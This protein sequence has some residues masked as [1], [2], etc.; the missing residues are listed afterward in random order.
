MGKY[1]QLKGQLTKF[2]GEPDYQSRV[3][4]EKDRIKEALTECGESHSVKNF[5]MFLIKAKVEKAALEAKIKEQNL[6]IEAMNQILVEMLEAET[7]SSFK[8]ENAVSISI[9]DDVYCSIS[10]K[11]A[12]YDWIKQSGLEDLFTVNYQT[13]SSMVKRKLIDGEEVPP[14][15]SSFFKQSITV[16][17]VSN[18][19]ES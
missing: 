7:M 9:K 11:P 3:N 17:G 8:L 12:F 16:R 10:D 18:L 14:G 19:D 5:G 6:T 2:S 15:I 13:M 4:S 1:T